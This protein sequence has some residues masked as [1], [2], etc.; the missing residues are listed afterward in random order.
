MQNT[1][2][3]KLKRQIE[4]EAKQIEKLDG[5]DLAV[6]LLSTCNA[7]LKMAERVFPSEGNDGI[8]DEVYANYLSFA[9]RV[10]RFY[11]FHA[12]SNENSDETIR[13]ELQ[14][15]LSKIQGK[16][17][18]ASSLQSQYEEAVATNKELQIRIEHLRKGL[19][20]QKTIKEGLD[21]MLKE[22]RP[23]MIEEQKCSNDQLFQTLSAQ[24]EKLRTLKEQYQKLEEEK[25]EVTK[26][27]SHTKKAIAD[28]PEEI[29]QLKDNYKELEKVLLELQNAETEYSPEKQ[30]NLQNRIDELIPV[31]EENKVATE[32]LTNRWESLNQ[33]NTIYDEERHTLTTN[34][35]DLITSSL[36]ELK[37]YIKNQ[38]EFLDHTESTANQLAENL[39]KCQSRHKEY[40]NWY[41][42]VESPLEAMIKGLEYPE[43]VDLK[44]TL[45]VG[46]V[47][48]IK[49]KLEDTRQNL[50][51][52][53]NILTRCADAAQKDLQRVRRR[54]RQ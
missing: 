13:G 33:Q 46:Q 22:C 28:I 24:K 4:Q 43:N 34:L 9:V 47:P 8:T 25:D 38:E 41:D 2:K 40:S 6:S 54:A 18:H 1:D 48:G 39:M 29:V 26:E 27:I 35:T 52:I 11:E 44:R 31:V 5:T 51:D 16:K 23:E 36:D 53:D 20:E 15:I 12:D 17:D 32:I 3:R 49:K 45:D 42:A 37:M 30:K 7:L 50:R 14:E 19:K 21:K 10:N